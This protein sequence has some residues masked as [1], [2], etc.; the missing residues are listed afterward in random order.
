VLGVLQPPAQHGPQQLM[1]T[2]LGAA[3]YTVMASAGDYLANPGGGLFGRL[4][5]GR[6]FTNN[7]DPVQRK[8]A[9][10]TV[11]PPAGCRFSIE[12]HGVWSRP[13]LN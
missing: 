6:G 2:M 7:V 9:E 8:T 13:R 4:Q 3:W 12:P 1:Q 11:R 5:V 10:P